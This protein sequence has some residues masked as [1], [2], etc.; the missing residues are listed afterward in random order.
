ME[1]QLIDI[2]KSME[3]AQIISEIFTSGILKQTQRIDQYKKMIRSNHK[4]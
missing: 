4:Q 1:K 2:R 3:T